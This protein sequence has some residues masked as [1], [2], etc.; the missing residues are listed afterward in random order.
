MAQT[1]VN[2]LET[3]LKEMEDKLIIGGENAFDVAARQSEE[4]QLKELY[5]EEQKR[6]ETMMLEELNENEEAHMFLEERFNDVQSEVE[7]KTA[8]IR[9]VW[10]RLQSKKVEIR[11]LHE[12][13]ESERLALYESIRDLAKDVRLLDAILNAFI[14]P[15]TLR[16]MM[17]RVEVEDTTGEVRI[18]HIAMAGNHLRKVKRQNVHPDSQQLEEAKALLKKTLIQDPGFS[19]YPTRDDRKGIEH[20]GQRPTRPPSHYSPKQR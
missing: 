17:R 9:K 7:A 16:L 4:L 15:D 10:V 20:R 1:N 14:P 11:D 3:R 12:E 6:R 2:D 5:L 18:P 19:N 13:F 8:A